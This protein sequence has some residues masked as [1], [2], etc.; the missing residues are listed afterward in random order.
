M[1]VLTEEICLQLNVYP[2][3]GMLNFEQIMIEAPL[4]SAAFNNEFGR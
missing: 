1:N 4:G 2:R 3:A